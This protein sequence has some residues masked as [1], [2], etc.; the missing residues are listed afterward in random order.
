MNYV[1]SICTRVLDSVKNLNPFKKDT[2]VT[3]H[4]STAEPQVE[5]PT[6]SSPP[7]LGKRTMKKSQRPMAE[8]FLIARVRRLANAADSVS[9]KGVCAALHKQHEDSGVRTCFMRLCQQGKLRRI[10]RGIYQSTERKPDSTQTAQDATVI[11]MYQKIE[12]L[13]NA[14]HVVSRSRVTELVQSTPH[15]KRFTDACRELIVAKAIHPVY[16]GKR[17]VF[18]SASAMQRR[19]EFLA[20]TVNKTWED[21]THERKRELILKWHEVVTPKEIAQKYNTTNGS[22]L[23]FVHKYFVTD[24]DNWNSWASYRYASVVFSKFKHASGE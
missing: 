4:E 6:Y 19:N 10:D 22:V 13:V 7:I 2:S 3:N 12:N 16:F 1:K 20:L 5:K 17:T 21:E 11:T 8:A 23:G 15:S 14:L 24:D 18:F 9:V